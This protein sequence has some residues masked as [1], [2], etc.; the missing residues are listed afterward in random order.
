MIVAPPGIDPTTGTGRGDALQGRRSH[1]PR[2]GTVARTGGATPLLWHYTCDHNAASIVA[3][4]ALVPNRHPLLP[5]VAPLVWMTDDPDAGRWD[6]GLTGVMLDCDRMAHRF[7][8]VDSST[9]QR[10]TDLVSA[11]PHGVLSDGG[12]YLLEHG[13]EFTSWWIS[14]LPV[15]VVLG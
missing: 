11:A 15:P 12:R 8:V 2:S 10:W 14:P 4:G 5:N 6:L 13:R 7:R 1:R 3:T 9:C